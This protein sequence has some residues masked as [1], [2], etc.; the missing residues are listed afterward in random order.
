M[1]WPTWL[2][3]LKIGETIEVVVKIMV[4]VAMVGE[5]VVVTTKMGEIEAT[6]TVEEVT[7]KPLSLMEIVTI[8][9]SMATRL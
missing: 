8:V 6:L 4:V 5:E 3:D 7:H 2:K 1:A 9:A